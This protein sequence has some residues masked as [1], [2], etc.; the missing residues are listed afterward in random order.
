MD[1]PRTYVTRYGI[2]PDTTVGTKEHLRVLIGN[3]LDDRPLESSSLL[4]ISDTTRSRKQIIMALASAD[5][6]TDDHD[7]VNGLTFL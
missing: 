3:Y 2:R 6:T 5:K 4:H 7:K 1:V